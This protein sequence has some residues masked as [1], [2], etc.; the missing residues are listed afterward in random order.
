MNAL[1][2]K[3]G[4]V[5]TNVI[6]QT[7]VISGK[8]TSRDPMFDV[9][10]R[11]KDSAGC[12]YKPDGTFAGEGHDDYNLVSETAPEDVVTE[13]V[14]DITEEVTPGF[15]GRF[16]GTVKSNPKTSAAVGVGVVG[17]IGGAYYLLAVRND[18]SSLASAAPAVEV[19]GSVVEI[20]KACASLPF[21]TILS[22]LFL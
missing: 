16:F 7:I 13:T 14:V 5:Y 21:G 12:A 19:V 18:G 11:F 22:R 1:S 20:G 6:G 2:L 17:G 3:S 8:L 4:G 15:F 10:A 9:G